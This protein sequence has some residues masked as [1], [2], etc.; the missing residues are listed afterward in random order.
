MYP[1]LAHLR[2]TGDVCCGLSLKTHSISILMALRL[3]LWCA[4]KTNRV[5]GRASRLLTLPVLL[6]RLVVFLLCVSGFSFTLGKKK[7]TIKKSVVIDN[8]LIIDNGKSIL[9]CIHILS[10]AWISDAYKICLCAGILRL[11]DGS[12]PVQVKGCWSVL[13]GR[14]FGVLRSAESGCP[15]GNP[16]NSSSWLAE[17]QRGFPNNLKYERTPKMYLCFWAKV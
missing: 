9:S 4:C 11:S 10:V 12:S 6:F 3:P 13:P 16:R 15:P 17:H 2:R 5:R 1:F 8:A 7:K 14:W